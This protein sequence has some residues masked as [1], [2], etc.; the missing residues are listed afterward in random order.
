MNSKKPF[1]IL[2]LLVLI[3]GISAVGVSAQS[4]DESPVMAYEVAEDGR[5]PINRMVDTSATFG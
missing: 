4:A 3:L 1:H 2:S 5:P